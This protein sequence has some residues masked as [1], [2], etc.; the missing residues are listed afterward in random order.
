MD[1]SHC[2]QA[3]LA[4]HI[5]SKCGW[6]AGKPFTLKA[7]RIHAQSKPKAEEEKVEVVQG[8]LER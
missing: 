6:F 3:I 7:V 5:C 8:E 1:C 2:G 4:R